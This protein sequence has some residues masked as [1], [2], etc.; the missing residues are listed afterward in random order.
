MSKKLTALLLAAIML[1]SVLVP[2]TAVYEGATVNAVLVGNNANNGRVDIILTDLS[3]EY[4]TSIQSPGN[5]TLTREIE[6][7]LG[8][9]SVLV[10]ISGNKPTASIIGFEEAAVEPDPDPGDEPEDEIEY[11]D[12]YIEPIK[13][14]T[15][16]IIK[17]KPDSNGI[18]WGAEPLVITIY[19]REPVDSIEWSDS[20]GILEGSFS[21]A[22]NTLSHST[23]IGQ[24]VL[25]LVP[26]EVGV[27]TVTV[28][29]IK[30]NAKGSTNFEV[31][32]TEFYDTGE[33]EWDTMPLHGG[34]AVC[35][36]IFHPTQPGIVYAQ[37]DVGGAWRFD[38]EYDEDGKAI[39]GW[40]HDIT[41]WITPSTQGAG[42]SRGLGV[43]PTP[44]RE[45]W[46]Y[47]AYG[48]NF[49]VSRDKGETWV[50][51]SNATG[52]SMGGN[53][54][55]LRGNGGDNVVAIPNQISGEPGSK[56]P[57][58]YGPST[59]YMV[60]Q[61]GIR[62]TTVSSNGAT[63]TWT[64]IASR[65]GNSGVYNFVVYDVDN[66]DIR[67]VGSV[68]NSSATADTSNVWIS[69]D[70]GETFLILPGK[71]VRR[72]TSTHYF[73]AKADITPAINEAGDKYIIVTFSCPNSAT[74]GLNDG[75]RGDGA[76]F[77]WLIN[78]NGVLLGQ[79]NGA[80]GLTTNGVNITP[81]MFHGTPID[82]SRAAATGTQN[83][84]AG[85]GFAAL[86]V[87]KTTGAIVAGTHN[88]DPYT[89]NPLTSHRG[90]EAMFRS[91]DYGETWFPILGGFE[92]FGDLAYG[93]YSPYAMP[94]VNGPHANNR[95]MNTMT[96]TEFWWEPWTWLHWNF[97]PKINPHEPDNMFFNSGLGTYV[98]YN[99]TALDEIA[100]TTGMAVPNARIAR[101]L[102][103]AQ[104]QNGI[105]TIVNRVV[106]NRPLSNYENFLYA[107]N[108]SLEPGPKGGKI[109]SLSDM[110]KWETAPGLYMTV[111]KHSALYSPPSGRNIVLSNTW[112]YPGWAFQATDQAPFNGW[113]Y[114]QWI[115]PKWNY[116]YT[117]PGV[118]FDWLEHTK[119]TDPRFL[120]PKPADA[121]EN[122]GTV[123]YSIYAIT[124]RGISGDNTD[125]PDAFPE[126]I[127]STARSDWHFMFKGGPIISF[128]GGHVWH[129]LPDGYD[130]LRG[131]VSGGA[132]WEPNPPGYAL[133]G[134]STNWDE[135]TAA[136]RTAITGTK[137]TSASPGSNPVG[138]VAISANAQTIIWGVGSGM[139]IQNTL[140]T[141][142][143]DG[144]LLT[145]GKSWAPI[146][147]YSAATGTA[148]VA[149]TTGIRVVADRVDPDVFYGFTSTAVYISVDAGATFRPAAHGSFP[150][151]G[152]QTGINGN[153]AIR[154]QVGVA[155]KLW[156]DGNG[157][158]EL[159]FNKETRTLSTRQIVGS[160]TNTARFGMEAGTNG[161][162]GFGLGID[163]D[164]NGAIY[165]Y[166]RTAPVVGNPGTG[167]GA[168]RSLDGGETWLRISPST[169]DP[170]PTGTEARPYQN[171]N[172]SFGD[173]RG[174]TGDPRVFGRVY[175]NQGN[176]AGGIRYGD[177]VTEEV[178]YD[179]EFNFIGA[180]GFEL[181]DSYSIR[182][183]LPVPAALLPEN[184][185]LFGD[186]WFLDEELTVPYV[187]GFASENL[188]LYSAVLVKAIATSKVTVVP[189]NT[190]HLF[191][192]IDEQFSN[193]FIVSTTEEFII[194]NN[195]EGFYTIETG[196]A[197][198]RVFVNTKGN[199]QIR[200]IYIAEGPAGVELIGIAVP[201]I[202]DAKPEDE[203]DH[204]DITDDENDDDID[205]EDG[206]DDG[207]EENPEE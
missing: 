31:F 170:E 82:I 166:G 57:T 176:V 30:G 92:M 17:A 45:D 28:T 54:G 46:V 133:L 78:K 90:H 71:P 23:G 2:A 195:A 144:D 91:L 167:W 9:Y 100:R 169:N 155:Y 85:V 104:A 124:Y 186:M 131:T 204:D 165:A 192:A 19:T 94:A 122:G 119:N 158:W 27:T 15:A 125:Y 149:G 35:G 50:V 173:V 118:S 81:Q 201:I 178:F 152:V 150:V 32:A 147:V 200:Q 72:T 207:E 198:Y 142:A 123:D 89:I 13:D 184:S 132:T 41:Q 16:R 64:N 69:N 128:D 127:V 87:C 116:L 175:L 56:N 203:D 101:G 113:S 145:F 107:G 44:G 197:T 174:T 6:S 141:V 36:Y 189:G 84:H 14:Q 111:Q 151:S 61:S 77:R 43:D 185:L 98:T 105:F 20:G 93:E 97:G 114:A 134:Q 47:L 55:N 29:A 88:T 154:G 199:D 26:T 83:W 129:N 75:Q 103:V 163:G 59:L 190:N 160:V 76:V 53:S 172:M 117:G 63:G 121:I 11:T 109:E 66:T 110:V 183:G 179:I 171:A 40:W 135:L 159:S 22:T 86:S 68:P 67:L 74:A 108:K 65:F 143:V 191:I 136:N 3:G 70:G 187:F 48:N 39:G 115:P 182:S 193:G 106:N 79:D 52:L 188:V 140:R 194:R 168:Y 12:L 137:P 126:I 99:L 120:P 148:V 139:N 161:R 73:P 95:N 21:S 25:T 80:G 24:Q 10:V 156:V 164:V 4:T 51:R 34:G 205:D 206:D 38:F 60:N 177:I 196:Y 112:D 130:R 96:A 33:Y 58:D 157:F 8:L 49:L 7:E 1:I 62:Q 180:D 37:T 153:R 162:A 146:I 5:T 18:N 181:I 102:T 42:Q 202:P 138:H